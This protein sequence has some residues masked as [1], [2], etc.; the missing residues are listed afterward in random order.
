MG[1]CF[2]CLDLGSY[3]RIGGYTEGKL[4]RGADAVASL[5][6]SWLYHP[7]AM[8]SQPPWNEWQIHARPLSPTQPDLASGQA[9]GPKLLG[10]LPVEVMW[11]CVSACVCAF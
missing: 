7:R 4:E 1:W 10:W 6:W 11:E 2:L 5:P 8:G 3:F 9:P